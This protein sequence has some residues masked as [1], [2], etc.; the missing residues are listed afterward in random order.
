MAK[1]G[2]LVQFKQVLP[3]DRLVKAIRLAEEARDKK[4][5]SELFSEA[6]A[7]GLATVQRKAVE[8]L[9]RINSTL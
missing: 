1:L 7:R 4:K 6:R 8:A 2:D 9:E 3:G 5:L